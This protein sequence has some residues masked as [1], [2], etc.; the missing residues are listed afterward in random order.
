L[1]AFNVMNSALHR[2]GAVRNCR[3][4]ARAR[5][6]LSPRSLKVRENSGRQ[7]RA[8]NALRAGFFPQLRDSAI[9]FG[10]QP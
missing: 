3:R 7:I 6:L 4:D 9:Y 5:E 1:P 2:A 8:F 10:L